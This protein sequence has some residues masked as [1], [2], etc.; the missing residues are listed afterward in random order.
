[1]LNPL[2][3]LLLGLWSLAATAQTTPP[4]A[5]P[6]PSATSPELR[7]GQRDTLAALDNLFQRRRRGGKVWLGIGVG[8]LLAVLQVAANPNSTSTNGVRTST[9]PNGGA[10][11][12]VGLLFVGI[13]AAVGI[14]KLANFSEPKAAEL[15]RAYRNGKPL[16]RALTRQLLPEDFK[17]QAH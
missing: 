9:S 3:V 12:V 15:S 2:L 1:M 5:T 14:S 10:V 11:A 4:P 7:L 6:A 8:G 16:P 13:P 17:K